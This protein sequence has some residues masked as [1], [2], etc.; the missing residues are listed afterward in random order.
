MREPGRHPLHDIAM[1]AADGGILQHDHDRRPLFGMDQARILCECDV[2]GPMPAVLDR[3]CSQIALDPRLRLT[4][5]GGPLFESAIVTHFLRRFDYVNV[6]VSRGPPTLI[7]C[8]SN[9]GNW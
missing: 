4:K 5:Q 2:I 6:Y 9:W 7:K 1:K 8:A 3:Y